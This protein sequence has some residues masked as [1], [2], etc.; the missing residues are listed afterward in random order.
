MLFL[1]DNQKAK[2]A[3][4]MGG[5][6]PAEEAPKPKSAAEMAAEKKER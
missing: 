6:A 2:V 5:G 1:D 3:K 4:M